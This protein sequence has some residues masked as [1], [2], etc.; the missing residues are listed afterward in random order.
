[1]VVHPRVFV[2]LRFGLCLRC[3]TLAGMVALA[4]CAAQNRQAAHFNV[5]QVKF[6]PDSFAIGQQGEQ[7]IRDVASLADG[8]GAA[9]ITIV[10]RTDA[11]G[12][13]AYNAQL[14]QKRATAVH[15]ALVATGKIKPARI[16]TA[17]ATA[18]PDSPIAI[19]SVYGPDSRVVDIFVR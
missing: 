5:Y 14:A 9:S 1:M 3:C 16:E 4:A 18:T 17:W 7:V 11:V 10:G 2:M 6:E 13:A 8:N 19:G 15:D 12:T